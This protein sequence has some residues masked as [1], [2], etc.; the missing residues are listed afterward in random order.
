MGIKKDREIILA[1]KLAEISELEDVLEAFIKGD[2][3]CFEEWLGQRLYRKK[4]RLNKYA[5]NTQN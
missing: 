2:E 3:E 4:Y 5:K 1:Q